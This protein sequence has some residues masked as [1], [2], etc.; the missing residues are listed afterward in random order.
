[1]KKNYFENCIT[2]EEIKKMY[3][4]LSKKFHPDLG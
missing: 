1:M 4:T 2:E 3:L